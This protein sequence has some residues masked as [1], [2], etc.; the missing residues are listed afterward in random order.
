MTVAEARDQ[1][2][3][4]AATADRCYWAHS[5][6]LVSAS[7]RARRRHAATMA[8]REAR[9]KAVAAEHR[10]TAGLPDSDLQWLLDNGWAPPADYPCPCST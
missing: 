3:E 5:T 8:A 1:L 7:P 2:L 6:D 9:A 10:A 4:A